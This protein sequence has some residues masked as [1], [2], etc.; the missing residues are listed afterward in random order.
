MMQRYYPILVTD[1]E[2]PGMD[3]SRC[4][5]VRNCSRRIVMRVY[6]RREMQRKHIICGTRGRGRRLLVKPCTTELI[7]RL[8]PRGRILAMEL[9]AR[10]ESAQS[11]A[12][13]HRRDG[14]APPTVDI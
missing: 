14:P 8:N 12:V 10:R 7:A 6:S 13:D 4:A 2:M 3:G 9:D 11:R 1:W 5:G